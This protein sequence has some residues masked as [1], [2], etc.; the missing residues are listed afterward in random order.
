MSENLNE[1]FKR[2]GSKKK[3]KVDKEELVNNPNWAMLRDFFL[4]NYEFV[5]MG[6]LSCDIGCK[7]WKGSRLL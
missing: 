7:Y 4:L 3:K 6:A 2:L 1:D 5:H